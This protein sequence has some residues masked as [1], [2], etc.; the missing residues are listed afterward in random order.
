M[1]GFRWVCGSVLLALFVNAWIVNWVNGWRLHVRHERREWFPLIGGFLGAGATWVLPIAGLSSY[2]WVPFI[3]D[4]GSAPGL[5][6][7]AWWH[8]K[9]LWN[10]RTHGG[11]GSPRNG[12]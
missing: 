9:R 11:G 12:G 1:I 2:W 10:Q 8:G 5:T 3:I 6:Y 7:T 4:W